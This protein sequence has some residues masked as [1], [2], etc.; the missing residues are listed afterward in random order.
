MGFWNSKEEIK[1]LRAPDVIFNGKM[2]N[3]KRDKLYKGWK[4]AIR[5][6]LSNY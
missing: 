4:E 5:R 3:R 2:D 6:T 1:A